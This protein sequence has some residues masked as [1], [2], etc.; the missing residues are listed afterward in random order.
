MLATYKPTLITQLEAYQPFDNHEESNRVAIL[1]FLKTQDEPFSRRNLAGHITGSAVL[2]DTSHTAMALIW[3]QKLGR[4]LQPGGHC[5]PDIDATTIQTAL[6]ELVEE[7]TIAPEKLHLINERPFDVD[8]HVIPAKAGEPQ[9][10]HYDI[11]YLFMTDKQNLPDDTT[12]FRW[13]SLWELKDFQEASLS[14]FAK[15]LLA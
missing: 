13:I 11:R 15:K 6:R 5:E 9:H 2:V 8:A 7:T 10:I 12:L 14:R 3:H 4:W 1:T